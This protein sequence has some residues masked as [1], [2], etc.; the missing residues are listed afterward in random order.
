MIATSEATRDP[1]WIFADSRFSEVGSAAPK[2]YRDAAEKRDV[3]FTPLIMT[4]GADENARRVVD[5]YR[6]ELG[7]TKLMDIG[8]L[9]G[10][11]EKEQMCRF[12]GRDELE[13]DVSNLS[14]RE[15]AENNV[16]HVLKVAALQ[17]Y[18]CTGASRLSGDE[19]LGRRDIQCSMISLL[20][21][22][23]KW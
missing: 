22:T 2:D 23:T 11:R 8:V 10:I 16:E 6:G 21:Q 1:V 19:G 7:C 17:V 12:G 3:P 9:K 4:C 15:A 20:K 18:P 13:V 5:E 14:P